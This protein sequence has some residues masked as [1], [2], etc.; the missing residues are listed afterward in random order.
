MNQT[1]KSSEHL[2]EKGA[3]GPPVDFVAIRLLQQDLGSQILGS[4]AKSFGFGVL[5]SVATRAYGIIMLVNLVRYSKLLRQ[6]KVCQFDI[7]RRVQQHIFR[8]QVPK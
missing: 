1:H 3:E 5:A 7:S 6:P 4:A 2:V 8:L